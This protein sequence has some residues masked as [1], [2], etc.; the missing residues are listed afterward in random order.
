M[1]KKIISV[2]Y[3]SFHC[4][5]QHGTAVLNL[6]CGHIRRMKKSQYRPEQCKTHC[7]ECET[8]SQYGEIAIGSEE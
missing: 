5:P 4:K 7:R 1:M 8:P 2:S 3:Y 6:E